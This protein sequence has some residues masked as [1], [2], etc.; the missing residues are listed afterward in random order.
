MAQEP[1]KA[2]S[3]LRPATPGDAALMRSL[4]AATHE[5][6]LAALAADPAMAETLT[7]MQ[8]DVQ[9]RSYR[10]AYPGATF[11]VVEVDAQPAG[12]LFVDRSDRTIHVIDIALLPERRGLGLGGTLLSALIAEAQAAG[13]SVTLSVRRDNERA[14]RLYARLGFTVMREGEFDLLLV[15]RPP[16]LAR[17]A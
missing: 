6:E 7:A 17:E 16:G 10:Q 3:S 9:Q 13:A 4:Y 15:R 8:S 1:A 5:R 14:R 2:A 11:D 12:R